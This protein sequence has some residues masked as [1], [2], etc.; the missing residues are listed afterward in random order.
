MRL[1]HSGRG[2]AV[3]AALGA[4]LACAPAALA[5]PLPKARYDGR[6]ATHKR[7]LVA[8]SKDGRSLKEFAFAPPTR[9]SDGKRRALVFVSDR[10][11]HLAIL[12]DSS[13]NRHEVVGPNRANMSG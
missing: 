3:G 12:P 13:F 11:T 4:T 5:G 1:E 9:C 8:T 6:D 7:A 10:R 2:I